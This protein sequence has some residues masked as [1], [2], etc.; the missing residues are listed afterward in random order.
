MPPGHQLGRLGWQQPP[1]AAAPRREP[2]G[3]VL[4]SPVRCGGPLPRPPAAQPP[5]AAP[6]CGRAAPEACRC[7]WCRAGRRRPPAEPVQPPAGNRLPQS[8]AGSARRRLA[9]QGWPPPPAA[10]AQWQGGHT[11]RREW[12][13]ALYASGTRMGLD[14]ARAGGC[15]AATTSPPPSSAGQPCTAQPCTAQPHS[16]APHSHAQLGHCRLTWQRRRAAGPRGGCAPSPTLLR[17]GERPRS[18]HGQTAQP[19]AWKGA[20]AGK[21]R[22]ELARLSRAGAHIKSKTRCP[23]H[24]GHLWQALAWHG[25]CTHRGA[26]PSKSVKSL[27]APASSNA[28]T[29][30]ARPPPAARHRGVRPMASTPLSGAPAAARTRTTAARPASAASHR[31]VWPVPSTLFSGAPAAARM[32]AQRARSASADGPAAIRPLTAQNSGSCP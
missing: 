29:T 15:A 12:S 24:A 2:P 28:S 31:A 10:C 18:R 7:G 23:V 3:R 13:I 6:G 17:P 14:G 19:R 5:G 9:C 8:T 32:R 20:G 21:G 27:S 30:A 22:E 16:H 26:V 25:R 4:Q 11:C 1:P